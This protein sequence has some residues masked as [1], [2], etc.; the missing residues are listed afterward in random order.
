MTHQ[1]F[2]QHRQT[3]EDAVE[4][5]RSRRHFSPYP[6][7]PSGRIYGETAKDDG[8]RAFE[9]RLNAPFEIDQPGEVA[10]VGRE[11]SPYGIDL[12]ITYPRPDLDTLLKAVEQ[13]RLDWR[14]ADVETRA[15]IALEIL[16]R[17]NQRSFEIA[18]AVMHTTGQGFM[19]AFQAGGPHA[20]DRGLEA[21]AYAYEAMTHCAREATWEKQV[22]KSETIT[23][24]K[25]FRIVPRGIASLVACSTFPCWNGYPGLFASFVTGNAVVVKPHPGAILPLAI[26]V[27]VMRD[28]LRESGFDPNVVTLA[29]DAAD[30]PLTKPLVTR[31]EV[32]LIDYTGGSE[33]GAWIE[34]H[35]SQAV[36]FTEKAGVNSIVIDS[37]PDLKALSANLAFTLCLYS[38]QMCTTTQN[39]F[40][41]RSGIDV[42]GERKSFD[43]VAEAIVKGVDWMLSDVKRANELLGAIQNDRTAAR[44]DQAAAEDG[45]EV[46]RAG[47]PIAHE[48]F[49]DARTRSPLLLKTDAARTD[50]YMREMFGPIAYL[51]ATDSTQQSIDLMTR[52]ARECG[53][54]TAGLYSNDPGVIETAQ[55]ATADAGVPLSCNLLGSIYVNQSAAFSDFHVSGLNPS[56]NATL[57]DL[58]YVANRF[59]TVQSRIPAAQAPGNSKTEEAVAAQG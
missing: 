27:E 58:A 41:P 7:V 47:D 36:T 35:A 11:R 51:V 50:R 37:V 24:N 2:E 34:Q 22:S 40:I 32:R 13:A 28:V 31:P 5:I 10:R 49:E 38:G 19:M 43:E 15:G 45:V 4:A 20:Q 52:C 17:L 6:E 1:L 3:L 18:S 46:L 48:Q 33:F 8:A 44:L 42:N 16:H 59:A 25:T 9:N 23:L 39:I 57:C 55:W 30:E 26:T 21:V 54:I 53:S 12:G 56:G 29:A 14:T